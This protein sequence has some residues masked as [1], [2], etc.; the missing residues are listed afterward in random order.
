MASALPRSADNAARGK[1]W[2]TGLKGHLLRYRRRIRLRTLARRKEILKLRGQ[3]MTFQA[4]GRELGISGA[5]VHQNWK[6]VWS[7]LHANEPDS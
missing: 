4:I 2:G 3:G 6:A 1:P 5:A 7:E